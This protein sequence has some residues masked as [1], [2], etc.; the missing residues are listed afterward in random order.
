MNI[1]QV[2]RL[3]LEGSHGAEGYWSRLISRP[4][5]CTM[6]GILRAMSTSHILWSFSQGAEVSEAEDTRCS[7]SNVCYTNIGTGRRDVGMKVEL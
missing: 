6:G 2:C 1:S 5:N 7:C 3:M 4:S